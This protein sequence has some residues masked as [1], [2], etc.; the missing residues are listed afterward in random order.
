M[1]AEQK[2]SVLDLISMKVPIRIIQ[3]KIDVEFQK[4]VGRKDLYNL[5]S[6]LKKADD[7]TL[8]AAETLLREKY[9]NILIH[10]L[11]YRYVYSNAIKS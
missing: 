9:G 10:E 11:L 7:D 8:P 2:K 1:N 5:G 6:S 3:K 4:K